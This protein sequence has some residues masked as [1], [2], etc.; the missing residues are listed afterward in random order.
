MLLHWANHSEIIH[1]ECAC[2]NKESPSQVTASSGRRV[3]LSRRAWHRCWQSAL[4]ENR[5]CELRDQQRRLAHSGRSSGAERG[6]NGQQD[7]LECSRAHYHCGYR[8][9]ACNHCPDASWVAYAITT[10]AVCNRHLVTS[11]DN[12]RTGKGAGIV[13][14]CPPYETKGRQEHG[15]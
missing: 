10:A 2:R 5:T 9:F 1:S 7:S 8:R 12:A 11:Q 3:R 15:R 14:L 4:I 13:R 6:A